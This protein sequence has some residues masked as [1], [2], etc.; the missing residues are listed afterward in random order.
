MNLYHCTID[1]KDDTRA[2]GFSQLV[3]QW[4]DLLK[5]EGRIR[6]WRLLRRKLNLAADECRDFLLEIEIDDLAQLDAAFR[7]AKSDNAQ[8]EK[9]YN[10][11]HGMIEVAK[12]GLYR[13]F[14]DPENAERM[15]LL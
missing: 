6:N 13:P 5:A 4:M 15:G 12:F 7:F 3:G 8:A 10:Q 9:L 14:P 2:L 1:L 11:L